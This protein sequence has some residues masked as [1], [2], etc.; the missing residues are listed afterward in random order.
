MVEELRKSFKFVL[1]QAANLANG[2]CA[3]RRQHRRELSRQ[4]LK[5]FDETASIKSEH[6]LERD[7]SEAVDESG[8]LSEDASLCDSECS[9]CE[10]ARVKRKTEELHA[11]LQEIASG[12]VS[13][14]DSVALEMQGQNMLGFDNIALIEEIERKR[15][16]P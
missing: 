2:L 11:Q 10:R 16:R 12:D 8:V 3:R 1:S 9:R 13:G 15:K 7:G 5:A 4:R 14:A 6:D